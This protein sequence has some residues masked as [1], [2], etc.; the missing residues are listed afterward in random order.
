MAVI[1]NSAFI[2]YKDEDGNVYLV[3]PI[4]TKD[5][6]DGLDEIETELATA[7]KF[8]SQEL[9]EEQK[10]IVRANIGAGTS[11]VKIGLPTS[12]EDDNGKF[13]TVENGVA[14]WKTIRN[15]EEVAY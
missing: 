6:V 12:T 2:K 11:N 15:A 13:L 14:I 9:T 1:E 10:A 8:V 5:N 7:V 3:Y 4:T